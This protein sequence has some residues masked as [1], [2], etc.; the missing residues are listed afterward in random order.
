M[1]DREGK[2]GGQMGAGGKSSWQARSRHRGMVSRQGDRW[3][4]MTGKWRNMVDD[5]GNV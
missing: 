1:M 5:R 2:D 3:T 4:G